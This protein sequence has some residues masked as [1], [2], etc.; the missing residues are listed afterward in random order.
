MSTEATQDAIN[1][2]LYADSVRYWLP[3]DTGYAVRLVRAA[4][5]GC[6]RPL[7]GWLPQRGPRCRLCGTI[8][9]LPTVQLWE[10][11]LRNRTVTTGLFS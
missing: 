1:E 3:C 10:A 4:G 5:C 11:L 6:S 7:L 9:D 8:A 2:A